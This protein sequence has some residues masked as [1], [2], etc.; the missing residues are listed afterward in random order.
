MAHSCPYVNKQ[1]VK[2][3]RLPHPDD[4]GAHE[5]YEQLAAPDPF[6]IQPTDPIAL[7][8]IRCWISAAT[9]MKVPKVKLQKAE[10]K[11]KEISRWQRR[12]GTRLP[13]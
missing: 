6:C 9:A 1:G 12:H 4:P 2:C 11:F 5:L 8:V 10:E 7:S 3:G 13:D